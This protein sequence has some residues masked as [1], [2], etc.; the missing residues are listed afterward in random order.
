LSL[1]LV[2]IVAAVSLAC[3][4]LFLIPWGKLF[5]AVA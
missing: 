3:F 4:M 2:M 5:A 1:E